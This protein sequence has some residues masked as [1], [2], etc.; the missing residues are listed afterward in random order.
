MAWLGEPAGYAPVRSEF[1]L[2]FLFSNSLPRAN[3][4]KMVSEYRSR[5]EYKYNELLQTQKELESETQLISAERKQ[6]L[7]A[8]IRY[9]IVSCEAAIKWCNEVADM[10]NE[11]K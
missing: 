10:F 4:L 3:I 2:K 9:G 1:M 7:E 6:Y 11:N 8:T 5:H